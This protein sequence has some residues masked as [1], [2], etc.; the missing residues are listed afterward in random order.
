[1]QSALEKKRE[2]IP[3][4]KEAYRVAK[5]RV[6]EAETALTLKVDIQT[7]KHELAWS[8]VH[9]VQEVRF[10]Y[11]NVSVAK[12][13][14]SFSSRSEC[15]FVPNCPGQR[16][17]RWAKNQGFTGGVCGKYMVQSCVIIYTDH[18]MLFLLT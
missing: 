18:A 1:M 3:E 10:F 13:A 9:Q 5:S 15:R 16:G 8:Y 14:E 7:M 4:M 2:V 17:K 6:K 12:F 11:S